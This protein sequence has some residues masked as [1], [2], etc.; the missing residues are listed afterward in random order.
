MSQQTTFTWA[1]WH[2]EARRRFGDDSR[3]WA[4]VCPSC[5]YVQSVQDYHDA[6]A[7]ESAIAFSCVG[8]WTGATQKIF[9]KKGGPCNYAGGGLFLL[10]PVAI[11]DGEHIH[12]LFAFAEPSI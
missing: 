9:S 7:P 6:S 8:R 10:N 5:G 12:H 3:H 2:A 1:E 11:H 4:F